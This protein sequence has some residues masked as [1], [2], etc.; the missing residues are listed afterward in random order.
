MRR[1]TDILT[2]LVVN[3]H[4]LRVPLAD[5]LPLRVVLDV[6]A[7]FGLIR[8]LLQRRPHGVGQ[9]QHGVEG[10]NKGGRQAGVFGR[11]SC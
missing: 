2:Y 7:V 4:V 10:N 1:A 11:T 6:V 9:R 3:R 5:A 8:G